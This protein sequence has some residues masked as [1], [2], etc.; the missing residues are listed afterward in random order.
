MD[1]VELIR[2]VIGT[3]EL[4]G[5]VCRNIGVM[6]AE[7]LIHLISGSTVLFCS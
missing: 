1:K 5:V 7:C 2:Y 4:S 6:A 3:V